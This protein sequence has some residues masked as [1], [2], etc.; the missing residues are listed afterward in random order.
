MSGYRKYPNN[1]S[2]SHN[3][4]DR[5]PKFAKKAFPSP[6]QIPA[7]ISTQ[8]V[9]NLCQ[10]LIL[11]NDYNFELCNGSFKNRST[12]DYAC[13]MRQSILNRCGPYSQD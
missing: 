2:Q 4:F 1:K 13:T 5:T 11:T 7:F 6:E 3:K 9:Y 12:R 8:N 10:S